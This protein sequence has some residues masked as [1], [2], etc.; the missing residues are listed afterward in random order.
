MTFDQQAHQPVR[1]GWFCPVD[2][3]EWPCA[4]YREYV[5][6]MSRDHIARAMYM[7]NYF[8][9]AI[10]EIDREGHQ[11]GDIHRRFF[12]WTRQLA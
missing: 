7:G 9:Q 8:A 4:P 1:P 5:L 2:G 3:E 11:P 10:V 6:D 12:E